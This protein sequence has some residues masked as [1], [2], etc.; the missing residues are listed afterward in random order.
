MPS[1]ENI[2]STRGFIYLY[3]PSTLHAASHCAC[4]SCLAL[5]ASNAGA[6]D[7]A[8]LARQLCAAL[9]CFACLLSRA[10]VSAGHS[11]HLPPTIQ[12]PS[13]P[14]A[15]Y[16]PTSPSPS[17]CP[18][19]STPHPSIHPPSPHRYAN[20]TCDFACQARAYQ[21]IPNHACRSKGWRC[22]CDH[23]ASTDLLLSTS[24]HIAPL[25][26]S[27]GSP[28]HRLTTAITTRDPSIDPQMAP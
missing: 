1:T 16:P 19:P 27:P 18:P 2:G 6:E 17:P 25:A 24:V 13:C 7:Q 9:L 23:R 5:A 21:S 14:R 12:H 28:H 22:I 10:G 20:T 4:H 11:Q 3:T 15:Q 26:I 8:L